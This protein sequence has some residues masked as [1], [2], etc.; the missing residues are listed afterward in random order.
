[1]QN[2]F[3]SIGFIWPTPAKE[4]TKSFQFEIDKYLQWRITLHFV[5]FTDLDNT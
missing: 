1:M 5:R 3:V 4:N 2:M